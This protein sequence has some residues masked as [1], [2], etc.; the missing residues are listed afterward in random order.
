MTSHRGRKASWESG[1]PC[2]SWCVCTTRRCRPNASLLF[3]EVVV[4]FV[5]IIIVV[6]TIIC[7]S[8]PMAVRVHITMMVA[9]IVVEVRSGCVSGMIHDSS[10]YN[11]R[12][13]HAC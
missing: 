3:K 1:G 9:V 13:S 11:I 2:R 8:V 7:I 6:V 5:V 12:K 10:V 4:A